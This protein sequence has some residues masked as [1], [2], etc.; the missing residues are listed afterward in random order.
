MQAVQYFLQAF[1]A[2]P[3]LL[4]KRG[5]YVLIGESA[6]RQPRVFL[7]RYDHGIVLGAKLE[8]V[9][10]LS[11]EEVAMAVLALLVLE[12]RRLFELEACSLLEIQHQLII[13]QWVEPASTSQSS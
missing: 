10:E 3:V 4:A 2:F 13:S 6:G 11:F 5:H 8:M 7:G 9:F 1:L 12:R